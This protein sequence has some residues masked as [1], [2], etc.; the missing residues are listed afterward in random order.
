MLHSSSKRRRGLFLVL[1]LLLTCGLAS[2]LFKHW[3][4]HALQPK[5]PHP[6]VN[7][8]V[9]AGGYGLLVVNA[10]AEQVVVYADSKIVGFTSRNGVLSVQL[11]VG[12]HRIAF[13]KPGYTACPPE[14]VAIKSGTTIEHDCKMQLVTGPPPP[15]AADAYATVESLPYAS[16]SIDNEFRGRTGNSGQ[17]IVRLSPGLHAINVTHD[18]Y[19]PE[20]QALQLKAGGN[21][22]LSIPLQALI[23]AVKPASRPVEAYLSVSPSTIKRGEPATLTWQTANADEI[24]IDGGIGHVP[25]AG[26]KVIAPTTSTTYTLSAKGDGGTSQ[27]TVRVDVADVTVTAPVDISPANA[28]DTNQIAA[29]IQMFTAAI[30]A[31]DVGRLQI[32]G[33]D[34]RVVSQWRAFFRDSPDARIAISCPASALSHSGTR[35]SWNCIVSMSSSAGTP[36][37]LSVAYRF[38]L[39]KTGAQWRIT[40]IQSPPAITTAYTVPAFPFPPPRATARAALPN[41]QADRKRPVKTLHDI[42][43]ILTSALDRTG[44][45]SRGYYACPGGFAIAT[46]LEQIFPDGRSMSPPDRFSLS[47]PLPT[48]F[49]LDYFKG[50]FIPRQGYFRIIVFLATDQPFPESTNAPTEAEA[51]KWPE[52]G[53]NILPPTIAAAPVRPYLTVTALVYEFRNSTAGNAAKFTLLDPDSIAR[54]E[55]LLDA[56]THLQQAGLWAALRLP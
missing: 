48:V 20:T 4:S 47:P 7:P 14:T 18:G 52:Q 13:S 21:A 35:A 25:A 23:P 32:L 39:A 56:R 5:Q 8:V 10:G 1:S 29:V 53:T 24:S 15:P 36:R 9:P 33:L 42:D 12:S 40:T 50:I 22:V 34:T 30:Q 26:Q 27:S 6:P 16:V 3:H 54:D 51:V 43:E 17:L 37:T 55:Q 38:D 31:H 44:Y 45:G 46:R 11:D 41:L 49:S 2:V 28:D 19:R